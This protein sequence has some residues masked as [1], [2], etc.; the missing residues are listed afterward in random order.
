MNI[1]VGNL[2]YS[3][4]ENDIRELFE[5]YGTVTSVKL[6]SD[7]ETG[8]LKGF[9]FV[10]MEDAAANNAIDELNGADFNGRNI[11]VNR[12]RERGSQPRN[13]FNRF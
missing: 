8:R 11:K 10:D 9:G 7:R 6:I 12:A 2:P 13:N 3:V 5:E 4:D 1:Y